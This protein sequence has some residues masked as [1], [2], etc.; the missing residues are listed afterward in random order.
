MK[1]FE[2]PQQL[3]VSGDWL[4]KCPRAHGDF[5]GMVVKWQWCR[6]T[7]RSEWPNEARAKNLCWE[8]LP[9]FTGN[10]AGW[11][12]FQGIHHGHHQYFQ[13]Y[14]WY[15]MNASKLSIRIHVWLA[16]PSPV[17]LQILFHTTSAF[18]DCETTHL[19]QKENYWVSLSR[20]VQAKFQFEQCQ[21]VLL[22]AC[23]KR[24]G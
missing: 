12:P 11:M 24:K 5:W 3:E 17:H 7:W 2:F 22:A 21:K 20:I 8:G 4:K 1:F 6:K 23:L 9:G 19:Y 10:P 14:S 16:R 13:H 15:A 18:G